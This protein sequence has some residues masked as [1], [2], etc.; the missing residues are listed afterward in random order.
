LHT[1]SDKGQCFYSKSEGRH[2]NYWPW[3]YLPPFSWQMRW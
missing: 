3:Q 2:F 1:K